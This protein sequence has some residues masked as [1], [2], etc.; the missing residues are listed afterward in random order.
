MGRKVYLG[1]MVRE[2]VFRWD[3]VVDGREELGGGFD[4]GL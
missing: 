1:M 2:W 3:V 4:F